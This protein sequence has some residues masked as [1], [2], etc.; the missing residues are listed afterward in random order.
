[1]GARG[2]I[3]PWLAVGVFGALLFVAIGTATAQSRED[4]GAPEGKAVQ[5]LTIAASLKDE[6][7]TLVDTEMSKSTTLGTIFSQV[8]ERTDVALSGPIGVSARD[9]TAYMLAQVEILEARA[10]AIHYL[11][12]TSRDASVGKYAALLDELY[13]QIRE[14]AGKPTGEIARA[15]RVIEIGIALAEIEAELQT[16]GCSAG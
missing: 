2:N 14:N 8:C 12:E 3:R 6:L 10:E 7:V 1:M 4:H 13:G 5:S 9:E 15:P 16:D 11:A